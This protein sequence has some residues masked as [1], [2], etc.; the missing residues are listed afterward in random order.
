MML[1]HGLILL[2]L[3]SLS[4]A[5]TAFDPLLLLL[6][7]ALRD[8][9]ISNSIERGV[10]SLRQDAI[11]PAPSFG[12]AL[13]SPPLQ[14]GTEE[15]R[16]R[17]LID[18]SFVYLSA[19]QRDAVFSSLRNILNDPQYAEIRGQIIA[20]FTIKANSARESYRALAALSGAEKHRLAA[21]A[22]EEFKRLAPEE[23][24][25]M[26]SALEA[27]VLPLPR[28]LAAAMLAQIKSGAAGASN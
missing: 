21:Q 13:P 27:G 4:T 9:A 24:R 1:R 22:A 15:G 11:A 20:E 8:H 5:A 18:E 2:L 7:R 14:Q 25:D 26:M 6:L 28:D 10:N 23:Q 12:Y 3:M 19:A 17:T 16:L